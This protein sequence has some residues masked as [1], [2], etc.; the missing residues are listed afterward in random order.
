MPQEVFGETVKPGLRNGFSIAGYCGGSRSAGP[1]LLGF[2][3]GTDA[4]WEGL[5]LLCG[6]AEKLEPEGDGE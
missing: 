4:S 5:K 2:R 3:E 6:D 1:A